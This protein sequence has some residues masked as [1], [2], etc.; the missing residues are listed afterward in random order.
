M[1]VA[2][3]W[4]QAVNTAPDIPVDKEGGVCL[5]VDG[6]TFSVSKPFLFYECPAT[7]KSAREVI[8]ESFSGSSGLVYLLLA[9]D[10][11][12]LFVLVQVCLDGDWV[13][14]ALLPYQES[15]DRV[16]LLQF[17][18][19]YSNAPGWAVSAANQQKLMNAIPKMA[20][21]RL[22]SKG[23]RPTVFLD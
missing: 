19:L 20:N 15:E 16:T 9:I 8:E 14:T 3:R 11:S 23:F 12:D 18:L 2:R 13:A 21:S 5:T 22:S 6:L 10:T 4:K 7:L 1:Y 17:A